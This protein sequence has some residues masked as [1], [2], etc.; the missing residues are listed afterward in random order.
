MLCQRRLRSKYICDTLDTGLTRANRVVMNLSITMSAVPS[1]NRFLG[2]LQTNQLGAQIQ[3]TPYKLSQDSVTKS[4]GFWKPA[5]KSTRSTRNESKI[6]S[7]IREDGRVISENFDAN[8]EAEH[9]FRPDL[10]GKSQVNVE[11]VAMDNRGETGS[12][13]SDRSE[14]MIIK[15]T[16]G[17]EVHYVDR[18]HGDG[19]NGYR[20]D[21][22][23]AG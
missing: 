9:R 8:Y 13:T 5:V 14:K 1:L 4:R 11:H 6:P 15:Q 22:N 16:V 12:R 19:E 2:E 23:H 3:N 10:V 20:N 7:H 18:N 17:W 21:E